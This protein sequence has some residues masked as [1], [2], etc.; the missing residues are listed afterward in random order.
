MLTTF[1]E[2]HSKYALKQQR[3]NHYNVKRNKRPW[4]NPGVGA[5]KRRYEAVSAITGDTEQK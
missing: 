3:L 1:L 5:V 2:E 4:N